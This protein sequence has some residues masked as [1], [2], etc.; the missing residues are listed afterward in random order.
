MAKIFYK[1]IVA[2]EMTFEEVPAFWRSKTEELINKEE[3]H[4]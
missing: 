2:G 3:N 4:E 1:R